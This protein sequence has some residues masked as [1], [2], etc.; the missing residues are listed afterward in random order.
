MMQFSRRAAKGLLPVPALAPVCLAQAELN[1]QCE[2]SRERQHLC[3]NPGPAARNSMRC[4]SLQDRPP[5]TIPPK[6]P[7]LSHRTIKTC[8][9]TGITNRGT[10]PQAGARPHSRRQRSCAAGVSAADDIRVNTVAVQFAQNRHGRNKL[11][12]EL[13]KYVVW[14]AWMNFNI[15]DMTHTA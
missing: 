3:R 12:L 7:V 5:R 10:G 2:D 11:L 6:P 9:D 1:Y 14:G 15:S 4:S 8:V 13:D